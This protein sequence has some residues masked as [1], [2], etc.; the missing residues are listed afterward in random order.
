MLGRAS[1]R[2]PS[3]RVKKLPSPVSQG[4]SALEN[5]ARPE[6]NAPN[7]ASAPKIM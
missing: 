3:R 2:L 4:C 7:P 5:P 1:R 6:V